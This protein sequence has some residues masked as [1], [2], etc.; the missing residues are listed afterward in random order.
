MDD[1][2][3]ELYCLKLRA[4]NAFDEIWSTLDDINDRLIMKEVVIKEIIPTM[5]IL[6]FLENIIDEKITEVIDNGR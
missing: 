1:F 6:N 3:K 2:G 5:H 4:D